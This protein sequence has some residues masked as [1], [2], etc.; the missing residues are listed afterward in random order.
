MGRPTLRTRIFAALT[1][2]PMTDA[3]LARCLDRPKSHVESVRQ[4][5]VRDGSIWVCGNRPKSPRVAGVVPRMYA[6][7]QV[8]P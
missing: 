8:A 5:M 1:L 2:S 3:E 6:A 7:T 4:S